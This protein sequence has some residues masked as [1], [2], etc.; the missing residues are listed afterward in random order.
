ME[1]TKRETNK[2]I[3]RMAAVLILMVGLVC[4]CGTEGS[5]A[6]TAPKTT[7]KTAPKTTPAKDS[8]GTSK[9]DPKATS[10]TVKVVEPS[11]KAAIKDRKTF[12]LTNSRI[13]S[14][15]MGYKIGRIDY[16]GREQELSYPNPVTLKWKT[17]K[18][19]TKKYVIKISDNEEMLLPKKYSTNK[20]EIQIFNLE[21]GKT[22]YWTVQALNKK[23]LVKSRVYSFKTKKGP[24]TL[25]VEGLSNARDAGAYKSKLGKVKQGMLYRSGRLDETTAAGK[26]GLKKTLGIKTDF[27]L[28]TPGEESA[29][30]GSPLGNVRYINIEGTYFKELVRGELDKNTMA[31]EIRVFAKKSNYPMVVHCSA[32]RDRSG[33]LLFV[34]G[35]LLGYSKA[36]LFKDYELTYFSVRGADG[37]WAAAKR[38]AAVLF[39]FNQIKKY[40][41]S[42]TP[43]SEKAELFARDMGV[44]RKTISKIRE[45]MIEDEDE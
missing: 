4:V 41:T 26:Q 44:S 36:D 27:D 32:G 38:E 1:K 17:Q 34:I 7:P 24:R 45:I 16:F 11:I 18:I 28:R 42:S 10:K 22:Y 12:N 5:F 2:V 31:R 14:W 20:K 25:M 13:D 40:G 35:S 3:A 23:K 43:Y 8:K 30:K 19:K 15:L 37:E 21:T 29:G 39:L 6:K 9:T 33:S